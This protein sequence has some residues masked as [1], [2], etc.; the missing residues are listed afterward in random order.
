VKTNFVL[1]WGTNWSGYALY[2]STNLTTWTKVTKSPTAV[3]VLNL[4]TNS[5][6]PGAT[7]YRLRLP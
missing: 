2:S 3:G 7:Y 4:L 6:T 1:S 5:V